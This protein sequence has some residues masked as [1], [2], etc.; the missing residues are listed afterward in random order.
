MTDPDTAQSAPSAAPDEEAAE[1]ALHDIVFH[2]QT[3]D[4]YEGL[5]VEPRVFANELLFSPFEHA[6]RGGGRMLDLGCG[7]GHLLRRYGPRF[8]SVTGVDH[9]P[10][11]LAIAKERLTSAGLSNVTLVQSDLFSFGC[12]DG[13]VHDLVTSVGCLHHLAPSR[14]EEFFPIAAAN[15][16]PGGHLLLSEPIELPGATEPAWIRRWNARSVVPKRADELARTQPDREPADES[17]EAPIPEAA[18]REWPARE[19]LQLVGTT[20]GWE[21]FQRAVPAGL[22][23]KVGLRLL[24]RLYGSNG[25]IL[26]ALWRKPA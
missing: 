20:R 6:L 7:T 18:L 24:H 12:P 9:S 15:L 23:D 26:A 11:M 5:I 8:G 13:A 21:M 2:A 19:G 14:L 3:A 4:L 17:E 1:H 16:A 10:D 25:N 22:A